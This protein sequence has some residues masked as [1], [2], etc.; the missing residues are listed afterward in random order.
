MPTRAVLFDLGNTLVSYYRANEFSP[1]LRRCVAACIGELRDEKDS[2]WDEDRIFDLA[3]TLNCEAPDHSVRPLTARLATLF[4]EYEN[5]TLMLERLSVAF[6]RPIFATAVLNPEA[7]PV[8]LTLRSRGI[9]SAIV[10]NTPWGSAAAAWREELE[11]HG[12]LRAV[13]A[14]VFCVETGFRKPSPAPI[15][16]ALKVLNIGAADAL[17]VG[18]DARWD[19]LGARAAGVHPVLLDPTGVCDVAL[20]VPVLRRLGDLLQF[21]TTAN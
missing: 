7:I 21:V 11:R 10:S 12:L 8:L 14:T 20:N 3:L 18:D 1:I 17:F 6:L 5:D 16:R 19:V 15:R 2:V 4:P 9:V 13:D